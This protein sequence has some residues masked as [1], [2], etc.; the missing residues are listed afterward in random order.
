V[1]DE[2]ALEVEL[3]QRLQ[4]GHEALAV[5]AGAGVVD[6]IGVPDPQVAV[7]RRHD[8]VAEHERAV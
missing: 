8:R 1:G 2:N 4:R 5:P 7:G 3:A 6:A